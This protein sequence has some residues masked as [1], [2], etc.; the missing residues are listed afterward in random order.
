MRGIG[1]LLVVGLILSATGREP[2]LGQEQVEIHKSRRLTASEKGRWDSLVVRYSRWDQARWEKHW[3]SLKKGLSETRVLA[4][5]GVP[6]KIADDPEAARNTWFYG[7]RKI[8]FS[9]IHNSV[10]AWE[11]D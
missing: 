6:D 10:W 11:T 7:K 5:F 3:S 4:L 8:I 2:C 1:R 9:A